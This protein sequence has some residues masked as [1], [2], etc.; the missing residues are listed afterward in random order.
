MTPNEER[1][2]EVKAE[3]M[4]AGQREVPNGRNFLAWTMRYQNN[5]DYRKRFDDSFDKPPGSK[6]CLDE[7]FCEKCG[8]RRYWCECR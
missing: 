4:L 7:M 1:D 8:R 3:K 5:S 6:E 2:F